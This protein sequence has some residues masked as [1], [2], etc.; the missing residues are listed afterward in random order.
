MSIIIRF[1]EF[2]RLPSFF[3][4]NIGIILWG[5]RGK[6]FDRF[7][8]YF[9]S[10][11]L[12]LTLLAELWYIISTISTDFITA[13]MGLS[14]VSFVVLAEVK[15]YY[16]IKYDMKVSTVLKRL[17]ALFPHTKEE[18]E[19]IQLIKYLKMSKFY[20]LFYT[21]TFML[22]IWTYNLYTV[23]QRFIYTKIL[24]VREIE[25][26]LPY[27]AIYFWNWQDNWSYF[28]LYIS[29][30]LAGWHAT[31]AQILTDLLICILISHLIMHYDH[32]A[33][34]LLNYQSKFAELYGKES[35][36]KCMPKLARVMM[37]ERAVR[38]DMKFLAD[39]IAYHTELLRFEILKY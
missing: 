18:Q 31:C 20:T 28:M 16:L 1:E 7:M 11:N 34:S 32:I 3:S 22:V 39:I 14:Y 30:S 15:F 27:P 37:E 13:I 23:S 19:N 29:Q 9:S 5:Q 24:Q 17:N 12:F 2:L 38:A 8:F 33:R 26:E 25:R 36:M 21:V 10:I 4:R 6:L 35:T